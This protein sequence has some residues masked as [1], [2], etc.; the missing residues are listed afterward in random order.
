MKKFS[1]SYDLDK[2][3]Q[4]YSRLTNRIKALGGTRILLSQWFISSNSTALNI[5]NDLIKYMDKND[6]LFVT[7]MNDY[8]WYNT[9]AEVKAA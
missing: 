8:A 7:D 3:G 5:A 6:R 4:D 9:L 2:P 1:I